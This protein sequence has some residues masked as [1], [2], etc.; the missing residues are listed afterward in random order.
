MNSN[1]LQ[2]AL[3][4]H[5]SLLPIAKGIGSNQNVSLITLN[6]LI[7]LMSVLRIKKEREQRKIRGIS[8]ILIFLFGKF[9]GLHKDQECE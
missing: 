3:I 7:T 9:P 6:I 5:L 4:L 1:D 2:F 8:D